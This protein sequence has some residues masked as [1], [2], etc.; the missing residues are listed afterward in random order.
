MRLSLCVLSIVAIRTDRIRMVEFM[1]HS[2]MDY[3]H[4]LDHKKCEPYIKDLLKDVYSCGGRVFGEYLRDVIMQDFFDRETL[5]FK[6]VDIWFSCDK[7]YQRF[8]LINEGAVKSGN[9]EWVDGYRYQQV[10][11]ILYHSGVPICPVTF[12]INPS[13]IPFAAFDIENLVMGVNV[14]DEY[15]NPKLFTVNGYE[16]EKIISSFESKTAVLTDGAD[17]DVRD[18]KKKNWTVLDRNGNPVN[19][20]IVDVVGITKFEIKNL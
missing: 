8:T 13:T 5:S 16:L 14:E 7:D 15:S 6:S 12:V 18:L 11:G 17:F 4:K 19:D 10:K 2:K 1:H 3:L 9:V 20:V